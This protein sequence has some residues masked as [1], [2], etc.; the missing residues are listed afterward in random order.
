[1]NAWNKQNVQNQTLIL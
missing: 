1:M